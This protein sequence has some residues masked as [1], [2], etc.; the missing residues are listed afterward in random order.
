[1]T[2][3]R[4][5]L[6]LNV[7]FLINQSVGYSRDFVFDIPSIHIPP[8]LLLNQLNGTTR[9]TR[10]AQGLLVQTRLQA[11]T[12]ADCVRCLESFEQQLEVDFTELYAFS[13][14]SQSE[15]ELLLP[16]NAHIDLS[17]LVREYMVVAFPIQP[18]CRPD[19]R[20]LC[21]ICGEDLNKAAE[22]FH[23]EPSDPKM[24]AVEPL[25]DQPE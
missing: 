2:D 3:S 25:L 6:R 15:N 12:A 4:N 19:C 20:G 21:P 10:T 22:H 24:A 1:M 5:P 7:G 14:K 23:E 8:D 11:G 16:E 18:V 9:V 17:P 13:R